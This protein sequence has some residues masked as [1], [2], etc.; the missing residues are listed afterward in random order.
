MD[1]AEEREYHSA[2]TAAAMNLLNN[3]G[4]MRGSSTSSLTIL[5]DARL[6]MA[7]SGTILYTGLLYLTAEDFAKQVLGVRIL[8]TFAF[9]NCNLSFFIDLKLPFVKQLLKSVRK[10][11]LSYFP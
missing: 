4:I 2:A 1:I 5:E 10:Y 9:N 3:L 8:A 11:C 7:E 6:K